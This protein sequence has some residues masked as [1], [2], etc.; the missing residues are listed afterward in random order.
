MSEGDGPL[1]F[2]STFTAEVQTAH[3]PNLTGVARA[4]LGGAHTLCQQW[5]QYRK[6]CVNLAGLHH[7]STKFQHK[8][9]SSVQLA[10]L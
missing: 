9:S 1:A 4:L 6:L 8:S 5:M 3:C 2:N 7:F 10:Q